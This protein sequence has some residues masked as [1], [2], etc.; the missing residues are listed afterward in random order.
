[1][2]HDNPASLVL[3]DEFEKANPKILNLF[4][5]V[6]DDGRL[7]DN[8]GITVSF[9]NA[10]I[11]ATSNGGSEFIREALEKP[12]AVINKA[13]HQKL[14]EYLQTNGVFKP[15]L[16]NRFDDIVTF[17]PLGKDQVGNVT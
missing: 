13:F 15:E 10:I 6:F 11:I 7:T 3:L 16:L 5:Q 8:K 17:R 2:I 12:G 14:L 1:K 4:L 9:R